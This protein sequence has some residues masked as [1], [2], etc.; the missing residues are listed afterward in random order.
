MAAL[1][2][3]SMVVPKGGAPRDKP[4]DKLCVSGE[5]DGTS[6]ACTPSHYKIIKKAAWLNARRLFRTA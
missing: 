6:S 2:E 1:T 5:N 4:V 3:N